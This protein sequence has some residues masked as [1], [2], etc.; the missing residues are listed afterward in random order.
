MSAGRG[1]ARSYAL[2]AAEGDLDGVVAE[3]H[4][5]AEYR[6]FGL[7]EGLRR[8]GCTVEVPTAGMPIGRQ[9]QFDARAK[10][11]RR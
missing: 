1:P 6:D 4:A 9:L 3:I 5:G 10:G 11:G 7:A 2:D 8:R